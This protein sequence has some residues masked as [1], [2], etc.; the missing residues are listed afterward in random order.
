MPDDE[1]VSL[2]VQIKAGR[3]D[4]F[5]RLIRAFQRPLYASVWRI[6]RNH[7]ETDDI[8][9]DAFIRLFQNRGR[10]DPTR[11]I[12]PYLRKIAVNLSINRVKTRKHTLPVD[13]MI[14]LHDDTDLMRLT[15][16]NETLATVAQAIKK[17]PENQRIVLQLRVQ[18]GL[19]YQEISETLEIKIGT[20]MSRLGRAREKLLEFIAKANNVLAKESIR[21]EL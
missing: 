12:Y 16:Q 7:H 14:N 3:R 19:S 4:A 11:P 5:S 8:L 1:Q 18:E 2:A 15:E 21:H 10:I 17:L 6:L 13:E 9:Q 20:V